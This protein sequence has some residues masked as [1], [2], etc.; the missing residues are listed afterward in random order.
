MPRAVAPR[1]AAC[2]ATRV[3]SRAAI[4]STGSAPCWTAMDEQAQRRHARGGRGAVGEVH[5]RDVG[6]DQ[7]DIADQLLGRD[8]LR[9]LDFGGDH[10]LAG[11]QT[12]FQ[13]GGRFGVGRG[14][15]YSE[16]PCHQSGWR[17]ERKMLSQVSLRAFGRKQAAEDFARCRLSSPG[18]P[19]RPAVR[20]PPVPIQGRQD[21]QQ[22]SWRP[23]LKARS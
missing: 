3:V 5:R 1:A 16:S 18:R 17:T 21:F 22:S 13:L 7:L 15:W 8:G 20:R 9:R 4:C 6:L 2:R 11:F 19:A 10:K 23:I 14:A 12:P